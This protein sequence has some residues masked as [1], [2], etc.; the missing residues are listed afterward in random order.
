[1]NDEEE[2]IN[3]LIGNRLFLFRES[4]KMSRIKLAR[5]L[6]ITQQQLNKYENGVNRISAA[7]LAIISKQL[8]IDIVYF[9]SDLILEKDLMSEINK[10]EL[11]SLISYYVNIK[12]S[13]RQYLIMQIVKELAIN[14]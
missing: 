13:N 2:N 1:M 9:Y 6:N 4:Q 10:N 14:K 3:R 7:K 12:N 8:H 11:N 5:V